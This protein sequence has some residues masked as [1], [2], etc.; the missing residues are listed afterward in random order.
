M[1]DIYVVN[2]MAKVKVFARDAK[3]HWSKLV[4]IAVELDTTSAP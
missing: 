1:G 2:V 3:G 4:A